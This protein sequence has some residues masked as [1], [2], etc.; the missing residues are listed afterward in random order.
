MD[1]AIEEGHQRC[2]DADMSDF[3]TTGEVASTG[4]GAAQ[5]RTVIAVTGQGAMQAPQ[6]VHFSVSISGNGLP[7]MRG[8]KRIARASQ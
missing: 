1:E 3:S 8:A 6:P 2:L 5:M 7:P 4:A